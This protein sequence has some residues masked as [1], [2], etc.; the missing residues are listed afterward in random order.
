MRPGEQRC[1]KSY[2]SAET[3][4][5]K[6]KKRYSTKFSQQPENVILSKK[7]TQNEPNS[8][9]PTLHEWDF[10][11]PLGGAYIE[12]FAMCA[13]KAERRS[14]KSYGLAVTSESKNK[15]KIWHQVLA[16]T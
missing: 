15:I 12:L 5:S 14:A 2:G 4:E 8:N 7:R 3:S 10:V 11:L 16:T 1:A 13:T 6:N 9:V